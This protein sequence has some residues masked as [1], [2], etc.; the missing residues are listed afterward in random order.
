MGNA[1]WVCFDCREAVRRPTHHTEAVPCPQCGRDCL[2]LGTKIRIPP[3]GD[4][5]AWKELRVSIREGRFSALQLAE[6]MR[7]RRRHYLER[8]IADLE[9]RPAK[10]GR[11]KTLKLLREE[12]AS[13]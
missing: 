8:K 7:A 4:D 2:C 11:A 6:N 3:R 13:M 10:E 5:K 12:L 9:S 1:T